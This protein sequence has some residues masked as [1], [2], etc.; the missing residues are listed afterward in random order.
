MTALTRSAT[1]R[2]HTD[3]R[4]QLIWP[5]DE[6]YD[7]ARRVWNGAIDRYPALIARADGTSDVS[8]TPPPRRPGWPPPAGS[9]APPASPG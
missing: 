1:D 2:L 6:E 9:W 5:G 7:A 4:G 8:W 3:F